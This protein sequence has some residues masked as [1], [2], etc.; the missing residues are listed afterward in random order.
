VGSPD[1]RCGPRLHERISQASKSFISD[2]VA[3]VHMATTVC[4]VIIGLSVVLV[5]LAHAQTLAAD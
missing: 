4:A 2:P 1:Q 5:V 3:N